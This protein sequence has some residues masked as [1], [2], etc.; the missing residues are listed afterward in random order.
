MWVWRGWDWHL[1]WL[2]WQWLR[3]QVDAVQSGLRHTH[4]F[5]QEEKWLERL[6][7]TCISKKK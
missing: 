4:E 6:P 5:L 1:V 7:Q 2:N 3:V